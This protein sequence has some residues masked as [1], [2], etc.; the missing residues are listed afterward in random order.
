MAKETSLFF[1]VMVKER[2]ITLCRLNFA[3]KEV[4]KLLAIFR[5]EITEMK[6]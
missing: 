6:N 2:L 3:V 1:L 4:R 5:P